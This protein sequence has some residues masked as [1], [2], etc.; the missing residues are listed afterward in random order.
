MFKWFSISKYKVSRY[1]NIA[2][3]GKETS[4]ISLYNVRNTVQMADSNKKCEDIS[5][6]I[7]YQFPLYHLQVWDIVQLSHRI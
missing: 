7:W 2:H 3:F 6:G 5:E 4:A 1:E